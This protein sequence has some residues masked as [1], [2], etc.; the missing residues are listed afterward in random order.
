MPKKEKEGQHTKEE[1]T[2]D[3]IRSP[4]TVILGHVDS[5]KTSLLDAVRGTA[6][7]AREAGGITQ[8]IGASFFPQ[9]TIESIGGSLLQ[10][11]NIQ[12][13]IPG[14]LIVDTP[15]H[16]SFN[17]L[18]AR[19]ASV[20]NFAILVVDVRR[21]VQPQT[22]E[23][24]RILRDRK[25]PFLVA[26]NKIDRFPGWKSKPELPLI[27]SLKMQ[28]SSIIETLDNFIYELMVDFAKFDFEVDL[29]MR[30]RD[31][32]KKVAVVPTSAISREGIPEMFLILAGLTQQFLREK[33][34]LSLGSGV[35]T[36][37]EVKE[38]VGLGT[39]LDVILY[40]GVI[41]TND[42]IIVGGL[43][44]AIKTYVRALLEPKP[45]DE[46]RDPRDRFKNVPQVVAAGGVKISAPALEGAVAGGPLRVVSSAD[47]V[48][49]LMEDV[50]QEVSQVIIETEG[51]GIILKSDSLGS[52]EA[53]VRYLKEQGV[54][55]R[56]ARVGPVS[57]REIIEAS[58][59]RETNESVGAVLAFHVGLLPNA[60]EEK[61][62]LGIPIFQND[63]IY[64][65]YEEYEVWVEDLQLRREAEALKELASPAKVKVLP[66]VFR[67]SH[68]A[69]VGVEVLAG[70]LKSR[71]TV[72]TPTNE[73]VGIVLQIQSQSET[74]PQAKVGEQVAIS[75]R[76]ATAGR[77]GLK[78][79]DELFVH[80]TETE[81]RQL[82][83][84]SKKSNLLPPTVIDALQQTAE[85]KR[86][87]EN[88]FWGL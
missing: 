55:I 1:A 71:V 13:E 75:I 36:I 38:E 57:R 59:V 82:F 10:Q 54:P 73:R 7:Q 3:L 4:I 76:G 87:F 15:G 62:K 69:V 14:I 21:G 83:E 85:I 19:G 30:I 8:H 46:I 49:G 9:E 68:P 48:D 12:V 37:L 11:F 6:V 41:R 52:L 88:K 26:A 58:I 60:E 16:A 86:K 29:F 28:P 51:E 72:L 45:L 70:I 44:G 27:E 17:N 63:I 35:G 43:K 32:T 39:T 66:Y 67:Q 80:L 20:A 23:S 34:V 64:R 50:E 78:E 24:I 5:G 33:L 2:K 31:Y 81:A 25:V 79:G 22:I 65:L 53:I 84:A 61:D 56:I 42:E 47:A 74:I 18:R 40:D 77:H